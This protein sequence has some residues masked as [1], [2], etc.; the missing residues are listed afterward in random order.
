M[1][2]HIGVLWSIQVDQYVFIWYHPIYNPRIKMTPVSSPLFFRYVCITQHDSMSWGL[3]WIHPMGV[4]KCQGWQRIWLRGCGSIGKKRWL[5]GGERLVYACDV[6]TCLMYIDIRIII[7][8]RIRFWWCLPFQSVCEIHEIHVGRV[9]F[10]ETS[11]L[12]I[13]PVPCVVIILDSSR[14]NPDSPWRS[15]RSIM[16]NFT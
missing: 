5:I 10:T 4:A 6:S 13:E 3:W 11:R 2:K 7:N 14:R 1:L 12:G 9:Y 15:M 8:R 16:M